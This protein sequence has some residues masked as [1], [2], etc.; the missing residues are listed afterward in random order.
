[1]LKRQAVVIFPAV[2]YELSL[3]ME[4]VKRESWRRS[5]SSP[6]IGILVL[7]ITL[8]RKYPDCSIIAW[9]VAKKD[10]ISGQFY[11]P[12]NWDNPV[13]ILPGLH[14]SRYFLIL[15]RLVHHNLVKHVLSVVKTV[16]DL[17]LIFAITPKSSFCSLQKF[18]VRKVLETCFKTTKSKT[19]CFDNGMLLTNSISFGG[20][21]QTT[22]LFTR[23][24]LT[25]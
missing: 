21:L 1:M 25:D 8:C 24:Y 9:S 16:Q 4:N 13:K 7:I 14:H 15:T 23:R 12:G 5:T 2:K 22:L 11:N 20:T 18:T 3:V 6:K 17:S 19:A 10:Q